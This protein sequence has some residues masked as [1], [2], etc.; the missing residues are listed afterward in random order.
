MRVHVA[1]KEFI[2]VDLVALYMASLRS[3]SVYVRGSSERSYR[4]FNYG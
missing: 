1:Y 3:S 2:G 4:V